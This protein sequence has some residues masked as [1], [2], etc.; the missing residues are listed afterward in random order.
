MKKQLKTLTA[1]VL[2]LVLTLSLTATVQSQ[3]Y[4]PDHP[5]S[6]DFNANIT[7]ASEA[8]EDLGFMF[9]MIFGDDIS[10]NISGSVDTTDDALALFAQLTLE[11]GFLQDAPIA[12]WVDSEAVVIELPLMLRSMMTLTAPELNS[13]YWVIPLPDLSDVS[14]GMAC[15]IEQNLAEDLVSDFLSA[16]A[17]FFYVVDFNFDYTDTSLNLALDFILDPDWEAIPMVL[18]VDAYLSNMDD[19]TVDM[20]AITLENSINLLEVSADAF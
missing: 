14:N 2:T 6:F 3:T 7:L 13:Q 8:F 12:L 16:L 9:T 10:L 15:S 1:L 20:P 11:N 19:T 4:T 5:Q 17:S 18:T